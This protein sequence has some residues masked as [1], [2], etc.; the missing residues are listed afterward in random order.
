[1]T[2]SADGIT[3]KGADEVLVIMKGATDFDPYQANYVSGVSADA[4]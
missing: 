4:L 3:V 2:T 1:M